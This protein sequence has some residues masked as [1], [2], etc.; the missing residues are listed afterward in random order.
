MESELDQLR[1]IA[2]GVGQIAEQE[3]RMAEEELQKADLEKESTK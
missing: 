3:R 1:Q 2:A